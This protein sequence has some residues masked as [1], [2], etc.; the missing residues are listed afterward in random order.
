MLSLEEYTEELDSN[1]GYCSNCDAIT[2]FGVE[3]D[4][5]NYV[6]PDCEK[7]TVYGLEEALL[8]GF[9]G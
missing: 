6:C 1:A 4:A 7:R 5:R 8:M 2:T 9:V 3:P